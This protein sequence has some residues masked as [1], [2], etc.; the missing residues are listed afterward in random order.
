MCDYCGGEHKMSKILKNI[1]RFYIDGFRNMTL[2]RVLWAV[3]VVKLIIMFGVL[4]VF[5]YDI[6]LS[7]IGDERAKS[8]FVLG[9]LTQPYIKQSKQSSTSSIDSHDNATQQ[10]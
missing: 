3:I 2:G 7:H 10:N 4:K 5:V 1:A 9:N 6:S 8:D